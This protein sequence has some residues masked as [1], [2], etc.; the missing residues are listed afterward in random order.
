MTSSN[1]SYLP[2]ILSPKTITLGVR[3][4][5]YEFWKGEVETQ[6]SP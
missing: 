4:S 6:I 2:K 3:A 1:P 5:I